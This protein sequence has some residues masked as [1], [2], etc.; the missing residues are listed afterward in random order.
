M[1]YMQWPIISRFCVS[2]LE[3]LSHTPVLGVYFAADILMALKIEPTRVPNED[4]V[5]IGETLPDRVCWRI[6]VELAQDMIQGH[7]S[8][9]R[10]SGVEDFPEAHRIQA[11]LINQRFDL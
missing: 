6:G 3:V 10:F 11:F 7:Y 2:E 5:V 4:V 1:N 9:V 8:L